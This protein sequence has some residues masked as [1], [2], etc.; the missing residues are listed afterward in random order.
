[1]LAKFKG[2]CSQKLTEPGMVR[3][4]GVLDFSRNEAPQLEHEHHIRS[5]DLL[6]YSVSQE[7]GHP[8]KSDP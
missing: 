3:F 8:S 5:I 7:I 2:M 1:M 6:G 4:A